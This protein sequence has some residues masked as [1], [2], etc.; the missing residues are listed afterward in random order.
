MRPLVEL[1]KAVQNAGYV[2]TLNLDILFPEM[3]QFW[4]AMGSM[5]ATTSAALTGTPLSVNKVERVTNQ[6]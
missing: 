5:L 4:V 2:V 6:F 3:K 1:H